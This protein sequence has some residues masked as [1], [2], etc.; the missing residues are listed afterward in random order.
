MSHPCN[1]LCPTKQIRNLVDFCFLAQPVTKKTLEVSSQN[2]PIQ[3][4]N[5]NPG[6]KGPPNHLNG[7]NHLLN[8]KNPLCLG[9]VV[10]LN[11]QQ[12]HIQTVKNI[13]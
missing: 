7:M 3:F 6:Q 2:F 10:S 9:R 8:V 12:I 11:F 5:R 13:V 4:L 1:L